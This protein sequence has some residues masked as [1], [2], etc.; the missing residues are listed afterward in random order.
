MSSHAHEP[1]PAGA[2]PTDEVEIHESREEIIANRKKCMRV[3]YL[4]LVATVLTVAASWI[5]F[6][7]TGHIIVALAIAAAKAVLVV[8]FFMHFLHERLTI[9]QFMALT[10]VFAAVLF[11]LTYMAWVDHPVL[12]FDVYGSPEAGP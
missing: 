1:M 5:P 6:N 10:M 12:P 7:M 2:E 8:L 4:L 3:F 9:Y 11:V